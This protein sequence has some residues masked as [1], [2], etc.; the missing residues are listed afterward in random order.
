MKK[1][2]NLLAAFMLLFL[3]VGAET[4]KTAPNANSALRVA[5]LNNDLELMAEAINKG[6][7]V[8]FV[9]SDYTDNPLSLAINSDN[10]PA[11]KLLLQKGANP[12]IYVEGNGVINATPLLKAIGRQNAAL[13]KLLV[14]AGANVNTPAHRYYQPEQKDLSPLMQAIIAIYTR[15]TMEIFDYL[16]VRGANVNYATYDGYT[17]L[18]VAASARHSIYKQEAVYT[19]AETLLK[20]GANSAARNSKGQTALDL[21]LDNN[22]SQLA[23]LLRHRKSGG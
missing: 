9:R 14:E 8:D 10:L 17:A 6:A 15:D 21:A 3:T 4:G 18:M 23:M 2:I 12:N 1:Y 16:L 11:V 5:I 7:D 22:F 19:M 20:N 13:V